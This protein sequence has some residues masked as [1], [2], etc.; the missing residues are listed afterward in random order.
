[1]ARPRSTGRGASHHGAAPSTR[2][3]D[4]EGG[5]TWD[6]TVAGPRTRAHFKQATGFAQVVVVTFKPGWSAPVLGVA[7]NELTDRFVYLE[8]LWG[9][10]GADLC[11][12][13]LEASSLREVLDR[14]A[15]AITLRATTAFEPASGH[16]AR[17]AVRLLEGGE[18]LVDRV[19]SLLGITPR[20]LRRAFTA[21]VGIGPKDFVRTL[22][23]LRAV[24]MART[25]SDEA[26]ASGV[27][28]IDTSDF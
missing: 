28:H 2:P 17:R 15:R 11:P 3:S 16:L 5:R 10:A 23:L 20:H 6:V 4:H 13:L 14:L 26:V 9:R 18:V 1:M 19:A 27:D 21:G 22:R 25:S 7:A 24:R 12:Q 8:E